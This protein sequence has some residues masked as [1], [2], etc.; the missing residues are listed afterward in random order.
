MKIPKAVYIIPFLILIT[1][2]V[3]SYFALIREDHRRSSLITGVPANVIKTEV[4]RTNDPETGKEQTVDTI[5]TF[6]Y[7]IDGKEYKRTAR[8]SNAEALSFV[9][10]DKAKVCYDP[11]NPKTLQE[12]ELFPSSYECGQ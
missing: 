2:V 12:A 5:V 9:P 8:K 4:R 6:V 1:A 7:E 11:G 3:G 10:W